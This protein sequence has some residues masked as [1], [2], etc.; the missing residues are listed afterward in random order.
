ME[1]IYKRLRRLWIARY[2]D[3]KVEVTFE[4]PEGHCGKNLGKNSKSTVSSQKQETTG[5]R[6]SAWHL[7][8][9]G[10]IN[11][12]DSHSQSF[13]S[14]PDAKILFLTSVNLLY[15]LLKKPCENWNLSKLRLFAK[16]PSFWKIL[17]FSKVFGKF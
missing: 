5:I 9:C 14:Q 15:I 1:N 17:R 2:T 11:W 7:R 12:K 4:I 3:I 16:V 6:M 13:L 8:F 10:L